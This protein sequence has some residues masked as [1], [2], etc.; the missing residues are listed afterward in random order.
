MKQCYSCEAF[1]REESLM[2][3]PYFLTTLAL[4]AA[5]SLSPP[6]MKVNRFQGNPSR[7]YLQLDQHK[8]I[9]SQKDSSIPFLILYESLTR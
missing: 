8:L 3:L 9:K 1:E 6:L 2:C 7:L 4:D 5:A